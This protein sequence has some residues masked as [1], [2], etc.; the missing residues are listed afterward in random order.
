MKTLV[1]SVFL[2]LC[3]F[4]CVDM[5]AFEQDSHNAMVEIMRACI[6]SGMTQEQLVMQVGLPSAKQSVTT[7]V[8]WVYE[9]IGYAGTVTT[10]QY[11][12]FG[13]FYSSSQNVVDKST[14]IIYFNYRGIMVNAS[15]AGPARG[16]FRYLHP[17]NK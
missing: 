2:F 14:I 1:I 17:I 3:L 11:N 13:T 5:I 16:A 7:G 9:L 12:A 6:D 8:I 15:V 10:G 4:G